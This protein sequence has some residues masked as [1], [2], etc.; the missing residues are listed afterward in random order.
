[1]TQN[2]SSSCGECRSGEHRTA[3]HN[4][5]DP[6]DREHIAYLLPD[7]EEVCRPCVEAPEAPYGNP[8]LFGRLSWAEY[9]GAYVHGS[10]CDLCGVQ[11][12]PPRPHSASECHIGDRCRYLAPGGTGHISDD[13]PRHGVWGTEID[14]LNAQ[15][16][17]QSVSV[18]WDVAELEEMS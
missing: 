14:R 18:R 2:K 15:I 7:G 10:C 12:T 1:M 3:L 4:F 13:D 11:I 16:D 6:T 8:Y 9:R 17:D 5:E